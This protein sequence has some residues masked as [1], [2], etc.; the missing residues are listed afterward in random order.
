MT[1]S[2]KNGAS[3]DTSQGDKIETVVLQTI[4]WILSKK[5]SLGKTAQTSRLG[6]VTP[7]QRL[8]EIDGLESLDLAELVIRLEQSFGF[9]P[10]SR[11]V[12]TP[13]E[14]VADLC[15]VYRTFQDNS[16]GES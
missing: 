12:T 11:G 6:A 16:S 3:S 14:T 2:Q 7:E 15:K 4:Q 1:D 10:F 9:D 13:L 5:E 8:R